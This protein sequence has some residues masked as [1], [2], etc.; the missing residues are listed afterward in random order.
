MLTGCHSSD[1]YYGSS[2]HGGSYGSV[3]HTG[4]PHSS[5]VYGTDDPVIA[6][7]VVGIYVIPAIIEGIDE[8]VHHLW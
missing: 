2:H 7:V 8:L 3:G 5:Y 6:A 4:G 1:H